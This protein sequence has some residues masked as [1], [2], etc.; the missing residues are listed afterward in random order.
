MPSIRRWNYNSLYYSTEDRLVNHLQ[1]V[2]NAAA[3]LIAGV[4]WSEHITPVLHQLHWLPVQQR[5][6]FKLST[7]IYRSLAGTMLRRTKLMSV[8]WSLP[9]AAVHCG[10]L[11]VEHAWSR[12]HITS[13]TTAVSPLPGRRC[14]TVC[15]NSFGNRTSPSDNLNDRLKRL[16]LA[17][18]AAAP[19]G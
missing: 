16:C 2:Q 14:G 3:R 17:S 1:S 13:S 18:T 12:S 6:E 8:R 15:L 11:T 9:L 19:C 4:R 5:V 7:L 10:L